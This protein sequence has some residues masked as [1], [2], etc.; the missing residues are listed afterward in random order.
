MK[1]LLKSSF[2][3]IFI[4]IGYTT[5]S[6]LQF[7]SKKSAIFLENLNIGVQTAIRWKMLNFTKVEK[8]HLN[9]LF[10]TNPMKIELFIK[11]KDSFR[12]L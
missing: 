4:S 8:R 9:P 1:N 10:Q 2:F 11:V 7:L 3:Y 12:N 6:L 5:Q